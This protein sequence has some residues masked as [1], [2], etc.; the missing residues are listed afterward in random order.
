MS[1]RVFN[2][3]VIQTKQELRKA[4]RAGKLAT[5][6]FNVL[7]EEE[8]LFVEMMV[9]GDYT[10]EQAY[11]AIK[12]KDKSPRASANRMASR[13]DV[14]AA[15]EELSLQKDKTFMSEISSARTTALSKLNY[16][17]S[18]TQDEAIAAACAKT[19]L[20]Q[21]GKIILDKSKKDEGIDQVRFKIEVD[22][23]YVN[24]TVNYNPHDPV[25]LDIDEAEEDETDLK[26][27]NLPVD[28]D[29]GLAYTLMYE[30]IDNYNTED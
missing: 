3:M 23:L 28:T 12:P 29:T 27:A 4:I 2:P 13:P 19:I 10:A 5:S 6:K 26:G 9:F 30:G 20:D 18:T 17:M 25:V 15:L 1:E 7:S 21:A 16:I 11:R 24:P 14:L 22:N 8:K